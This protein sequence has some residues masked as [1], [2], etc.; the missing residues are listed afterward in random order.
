MDKYMN[1]V[2]NLMQ[3][4]PLE[5][6]ITVSEN[7]SENFYLSGGDTKYTP[8][9]GFPPIYVCEKKVDAKLET[10]EGKPK[11]EYE[12]HQTS[13]SIKNIMETRRKATP[14]FSLD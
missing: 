14:F 12:S 11:R 2:D 10:D 7:S 4:H 9:G 8:T 13:V 1:Y 6:T 3:N 5:D